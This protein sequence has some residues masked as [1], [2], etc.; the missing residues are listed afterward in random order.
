MSS[1]APYE[2]CSE[3]RMR[4]RSPCSRV[5]QSVSHSWETFFTFTHILRGMPIQAKTRCADSHPIEEC[6][7]RQNA[8]TCMSLRLTAVPS[9]RALPTTVKHHQPT[10]TR[11][12]SPPNLLPR[13]QHHARSRLFVEGP[14]HTQRQVRYDTRC[15]PI[16]LC[17]PAVQCTLP[18]ISQ[19]AD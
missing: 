12:E 17:C 2:G 5:G 10:H 7:G 8:T 18:P 4:S 13:Q 6:D 15:E 3:S 9:A 19:S 1:T 11:C 14:L 16:E